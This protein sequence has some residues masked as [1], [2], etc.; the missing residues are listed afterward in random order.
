MQVHSRQLNSFYLTA[1]RASVEFSGKKNHN[2]CLFDNQI[3]FSPIV[4]QSCNSP[5][6]FNKITTKVS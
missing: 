1:A 6:P 3:F 2:A 4:V 5:G